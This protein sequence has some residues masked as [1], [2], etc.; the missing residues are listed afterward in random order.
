[1]GKQGFII[2]APNALIMTPQG[3]SS[4]VSATSGEINFGGDSISINGGWSLYDLIEIDT[5]STIEIALTEA[6]WKMTN[7]QLTSGGK[8]TTGKADK[9]YFGD[10]YIAK[11][12]AITIPYEVKT[13]S[14]RISGFSETADVV[15]TKEFKVTVG[16]GSTTVTFFADE[17]ADGEEVTPSFAVEV[18]SSE[19]L[20]VKTT[21]AP[22]SGQVVLQFPVYDDKDGVGIQGYLQ[23]IVYSAKI[24]RANKI[25]GAYKTASTF[26]LSIKGL[27]PRRVDKNMFEMAFIPVA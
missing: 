19:I 16:E 6:Q 15:A 26:D 13:G 2:D 25:G 1:M 7:M 3:D 5:K 21:D 20:T 8:V 22:K 14:L 4:I 24:Q 9:Y 10:I 17:V 23:I 11:D 12:D 27:D 18:D